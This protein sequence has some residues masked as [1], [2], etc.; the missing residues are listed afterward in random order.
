MQAQLW[1]LNLLAPNRVAHLLLPENEAHYRLIPPRGFSINYGVEHEAYAYQL[2][3]DIGGSAGFWEVL[4]A[5]WTGSSQ[6]SWYKLPLVWALGS[7]YNVKF[8]LRGPWQW[9][10]AEKVLVGELWNT[11]E[12]RGGFVG[13]LLPGFGMDIMVTSKI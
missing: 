5:G 10:G 11:I 7:N 13:K 6:G 3:L 12:R 1:V 9:E 4:R 8:R 2:A